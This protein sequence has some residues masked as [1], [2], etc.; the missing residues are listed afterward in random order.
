MQKEQTQVNPARKKTL[1]YIQC[2]NSNDLN[3]LLNANLTF[4]NEKSTTSL[5]FGKKI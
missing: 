2:L 1:L 5:K 3:L 4:F